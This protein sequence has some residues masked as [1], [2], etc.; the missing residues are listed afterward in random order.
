MWEA[1]NLHISNDLYRMISV[2]I[3]TT[4]SKLSNLSLTTIQEIKES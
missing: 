3:I 1:T 4:F 2:K